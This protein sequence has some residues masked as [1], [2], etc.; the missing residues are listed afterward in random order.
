MMSIGLRDVAV[1]ALLSCVAGSGL[2]WATCTFD[3]NGDA[4]PDL[5]VPDRDGDGFCDFPDGRTHISGKLVFRA[6][7]RVRFR[8]SPVIE[9]DEIVVEPGAIVRGD[10]RTLLSLTMIALRGD[11]RS[12]GTFAIGAGHDATFSSQAG[13]VEFR[14]P[15]TISAGRRAWLEARDDG[16]T[17]A[18]PSGVPGGSFTILAPQ[19]VIRTPSGVGAILLS[20]ARV[21]GRSVTLDATTLRPIIGLK[22]I[23]VDDGSVVTTDLDRTGFQGPAGDI[24]VRAGG[25]IDVTSDSQLDSGHDLKI[26]TTR[27][28]DDLC[29]ANTA[30]L[31]ARHRG[32]Q[33]GVID[34]RG[35]RGQVQDDSTDVEDG[36][37]AAPRLRGACGRGSC[38]AALGEVP[39]A[40]EAGDL[41]APQAQA[42]RPKPAPGSPEAEF[43]KWHD[44]VRMNAVPKP[45][46]A[47][48]MEWDDQ[49]ETSAKYWANLLVTRKSEKIPLGR[50]AVGCDEA[51]DK[52]SPY[53]DQTSPHSFH[54]GLVDRKLTAVEGLKTSNRSVLQD[55]KGNLLNEE[56]K[57]VDPKDVKAREVRKDLGGGVTEITHVPDGYVRVGENIA[58][59]TGHL[60]VA[61]AAEQAMCGGGGCKKPK[62][63][64]DKAWA[65]NER[66]AF[67]YFARKKGADGCSLG[68]GCCGHYTQVVWAASMKVGCA[69]A[70][71]PADS[72]MWGTVVVCQ[73]RPQ[74]NVSVNGARQVPY[75]TK[76]KEP[77]KK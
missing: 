61:A 35:V 75:T 8:G 13:S 2:T 16:I 56:G 45:D 28:V 37:V 51:E 65:A 25:P 64:T 68:P 48:K 29:L 17:L 12:L 52:D 6:G 32:G 22:R 69:V 43:M 3:T 62:G 76:E 53:E 23:E 46:P 40:R 49:L 54:R 20:A 71:C 19:V 67:D 10:R 73:Y 72:K 41:P 47:L 33:R 55:E 34:L 15:T 9:A 58:Q 59:F 21:G 60:N 44:F 57:V 11:L 27:S 42:K 18:P 74:G 30:V 39:E 50:A 26:S 70:T 63:D 1:V 5:V 24:V 36:R 38:E 66:T 7:D 77:E 31:Q 14:G 4:S